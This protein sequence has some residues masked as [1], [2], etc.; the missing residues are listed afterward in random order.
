ML[1]SGVHE[2]LTMKKSGE[3]TIERD[4]RRYGA[5]YQIRDGMMEIKT[6]T[7]TR[8]VAIGDRDPDAVA[9][10]VLEEVVKAHS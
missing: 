7:E 2:E 8:S 6:H 4:G 10:S 9:R 1:R 5:T 3:V